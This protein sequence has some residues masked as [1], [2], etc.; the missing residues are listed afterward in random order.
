MKHDHHF[1]MGHQGGQ[2]REGAD[3]WTYSGPARADQRTWDNIRLTRQSIGA[4]RLDMGEP[5]SLGLA[6]RSSVGGLWEL[7]VE[8]HWVIYASLRSNELN[9]FP[10]SPAWRPRVQRSLKSCEGQ[11]PF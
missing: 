6:P 5:M 2:K 3:R 10:Q 7:A 11:T 8:E 1:A 4:R 9:G